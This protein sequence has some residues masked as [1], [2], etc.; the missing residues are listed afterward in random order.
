[1]VNIFGQYEELVKLMHRAFFFEDGRTTGSELLI[2]ESK[3]I[4]R[5]T[6]WIERNARSIGS[7]IF[8]I[9]SYKLKKNR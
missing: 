6:S 7:Q 2:H 3:L 9:S 4:F 8:G 5:Q 1:M